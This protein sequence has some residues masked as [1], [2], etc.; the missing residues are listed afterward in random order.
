MYQYKVK[1]VVKVVDGDTVDFIIDLGFKTFIK[2][3]VRLYGI[4]TP[5]TRL[6]KCIANVEERHKEKKR[7]L[8][9]KEIVKRILYEAKNIKL[10]SKGIGK[11]GRS[12]GVITID[13][14]EESLNDYLLNNGHAVKM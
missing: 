11:Y 13:G 1:E 4:D 14:M 5:E 3:R 8:E 7:G 10:D 12:L 9:V 2:T 6:Q